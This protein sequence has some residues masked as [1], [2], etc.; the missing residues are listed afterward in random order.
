MSNGSVI[1]IYLINYS[2]DFHLKSHLF[3][4]VGKFVERNV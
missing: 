4:E 2:I 3:I 1:G